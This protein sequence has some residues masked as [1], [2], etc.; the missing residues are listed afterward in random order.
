MKQIK[1]LHFSDLHLDY[2][3]TS[4]GPD[5]GKIN[6]RRKDLLEVFDR[7]IELTKRENA[8]LL[9]ISGD[10][11]EHFYVKKS[12]IK[13]VN[14]K[15][16]EIDDKKVFIVPGNHDPYLT[17]SYYMNFQWNSNVYI[18]SEERYKVEI[19][20]L[21]TCIYGLGFESFY[22]NGSI[23][24]EIKS[25]NDEK[26]N[27]LL[28]HG[29]VDMNFTKTGYN[30]FTSEELAQLNMDYIALGHFHN[31]IDDVGKKGLIYN[32]GSPE[33][34][35]FDEEGEHGVFVGKLS[36]ELLDIKYINTNRRYYKSVNINVEDIGSSEQAA[37]KICFSLE[38]L[39]KEDVLLSVTLKGFAKDEYGINKEKI[40]S[41]LEDSFF[42]VNIEDRTIPDFDYE[43]LKTEPGLK[44]L[45]VRKLMGM[46]DKAKN[47]KEKYLLMKSLYYGLQALDKGKIDEL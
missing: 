13:H 31:R 24:D 3:F 8:D 29:T 26:I 11:Y 5:L 10:L 42:Y 40:K 38:G 18:L 28:V 39:P 45:Y 23:M 34:L 1:F 25:V 19:E 30:L 21:N 32:P 36:K 22:N 12:T 2:P 7:I 27:I 16:K 4:L 35:G 47:E 43:E 37:E 41:S 15:F 9:L 17:N 46:I 33:P 20:E 44:G 14:D 6:Q